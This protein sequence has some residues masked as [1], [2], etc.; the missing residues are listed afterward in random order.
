MKR[1]EIGMNTVKRYLFI[2]AALAI[3]CTSILPTTVMAQTID[4]KANA[5]HQ[6]S[7]LADTAANSNLSERLS[8]TKG[9]VLAVLILSHQVKI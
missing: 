2:L 3:L 5:L 7:I 8:E 1:R 6:L 9:T 4:E